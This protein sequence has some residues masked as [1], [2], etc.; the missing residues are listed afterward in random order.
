MQRQRSSSELRAGQHGQERR[1][2]VNRRYGELYGDSLRAMKTDGV[3]V[4]DCFDEGSDDLTVDGQGLS[5][6]Y[7]LE[8]RDPRV[9]GARVHTSM[10]S[11]CPDFFQSS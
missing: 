1:P 3:L 10:V 5:V 9:L 8:Q 7:R 6:R 2:D 4:A 11:G